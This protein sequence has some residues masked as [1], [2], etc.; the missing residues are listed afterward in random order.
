MHAM[1]QPTKQGDIV[2]LDRRTGEP[3]LPVQEA[4][5][6]GRAVQGDRTAPTLPVSAHSFNPS[7]LTE[8]NM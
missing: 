5:A 7:P 8:R 3:L 4:S 1:V 6:P 2:A